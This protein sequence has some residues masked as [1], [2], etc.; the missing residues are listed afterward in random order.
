VADKAVV[1]LLYEGRHS[2]QSVDADHID[3]YFA[4]I[5]ENL[6]DKQKADLKRKF[7]RAD[8][9]NIAD[10]K[11]NE[12]AR[13]IS[14]HYRD[15]WQHTGFKGQLVCPNKSAAIKYKKYLDEI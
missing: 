13:D 7:A 3:R 1:P 9:L 8:Q 5:S 6:T 15:N 4:R 10:K 12:I 11:I 2:A 14:L